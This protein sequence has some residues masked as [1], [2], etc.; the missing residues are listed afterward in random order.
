[1]SWQNSITSKRNFC[2]KY[3]SSVLITDIV[4]QFS[5]KRGEVIMFSENLHNRVKTINS[6]LFPT[7]V[8]HFWF[9]L[10][11]LLNLF[12]SRE[13]YSAK[14]LS[15]WMTCRLQTSF[16]VIVHHQSTCILE[17]LFV[18]V[19]FL[20]LQCAYVESALNLLRIKHDKLKSKVLAYDASKRC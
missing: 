7:V 12:S 9:F 19:S 16:I 13:N 3:S 20:C 15:N 11:L 6:L 4:F 10:V 14:Q 2:A 8:M 18:I 1:M 5:T 17:D